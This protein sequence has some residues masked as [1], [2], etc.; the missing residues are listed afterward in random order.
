MIRHGFRP[1]KGLG[2]TLQGM[3]EPITLSVI[4]K[5]FGLGFKPTP[6]DEKWAKKRRNEGWK[7]PQPLPDLYA[8]FV[9]P[10]YAEEEDDEVFTAEEIEEICGAMREMLYEVHMVQ[11]GEGTSTAEMLYMGP[12]AQ[13]QNWEATPFPT[14]RKSG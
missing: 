3:T 10:R 11:P 2:R 5:P 13:L 1:G 9:R 6:T 7:L 8:T 12:N 14:R 4:K